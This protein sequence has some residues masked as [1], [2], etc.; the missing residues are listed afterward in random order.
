VQSFAHADL[1]MAYRTYGH[2][3]VPVIAFHGFAR[4]GEDFAFLAPFI[5]ERCTLH[6]FDLPFHGDSPSP[7]DRVD[8]PIA[9]EEL[10]AFFTAFADHLDAP[11]LTVMG[12]SLGGR[13]ALSLLER[14]PARIA[15]GFLIAPDG[16]KHRPWYRGLAG[17]AIGRRIYAHFIDRPQVVHGL[18]NT[19]RA[20]RLLGDRMHRF[21]IGQS[22]TREKRLLMR[23]IWLAFRTIEPSLS[24]VAANVRQHNIPLQLVFGDRDKVIRPEFGK[25][26]SSLA[27]EQV[28]T[29][30]IPTGHVVLIPEFGEW[31][32]GEAL[33]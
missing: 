13:I 32:Q 20:V 1:T 24:T 19:L 4:T 18:I 14:M 16:L 6:A 26:L 15:K 23:N 7:T 30:L 33:S 25:A 21:L 31:L 27:P 2:G 11:R 28:R 8:R 12:Y 29:Q 22:D 17:S 10:A 5:G 3:P 9:P